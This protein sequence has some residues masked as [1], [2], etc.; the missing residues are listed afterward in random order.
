M[1]ESVSTVVITRL[2][3]DD[4]GESHFVDETV[5]TGEVNFAPPAPSM[6]ASTPFP[7]GQVLYL[8]LPEGWYGDL[9]PAP[10]RQL[11]TLLSGELEVNASD[12]ETRRFNP[13]GSVLV[14]DTTG[15]GHATKTVGGPSVLAVVQ[16]P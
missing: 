10:R 9:H 8:L 3:A 13:G 4:A 15:K 16:L 12:G 2:Y 1:S 6:Y 11:M 14:E 7:A 5:R